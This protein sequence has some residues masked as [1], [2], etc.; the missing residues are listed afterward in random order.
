[1]YALLLLLT[2]VV[3]CIML[4]P[5]LQDSLASVPFCKVRLEYFC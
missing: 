2:T 5:G 3:C 4:A 1:M